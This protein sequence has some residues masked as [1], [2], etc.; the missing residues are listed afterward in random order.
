VITIPTGDFVGLLADVIPFASTDDEI[1]SVN[2]V[3]L[4]WVGTRLD[5]LA[6][7]RYRIAVSEWEPGDT[8][9]DEAIQDDLFSDWGSGDDPWRTTIALDDAKE[10]VKVFKLG[11]KEYSVPLS[12]DYEF[13][14]AR[15]TVKRAKETGHSAITIVLE[16]TEVEFPDVRALLSKNDALKPVT[17]LGYTAKLLAD[18]GKVRPRGPLELS[19]TGAEGLTHVSIGERFHGAIMPVRIGDG[20]P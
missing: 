10:L 7:D 13:G 3:R 19:F 2:C 4:E 8:G 9:K 14:R 15:F 16:T 12:V 18:F 6:T 11:E 17:S 20:G 5:A 1:P